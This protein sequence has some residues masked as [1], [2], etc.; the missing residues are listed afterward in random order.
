MKT[1][2]WAIIILM[3]SIIVGAFFLLENPDRFKAQISS[4]VASNSDYELEIGGELGWR[5]WPP[6]AIEA[7]N[8]SIA[9]KGAD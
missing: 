4:V 2:F 7:S 9:V 8:V 1:V 6:I 3:S 5:Y